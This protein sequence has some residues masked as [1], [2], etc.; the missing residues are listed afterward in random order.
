MRKLIN[1]FFVAAALMLTANIAN[2]QQK[3][4]HLN[5]DD[6][7]DAMPEAKTAQATLETLA[8]TRQTE[9]EKMVSE[10]Q[11]KL[12]AAQDKEKVA[13]EK[14]RNISEANRDVITK[15]LDVLAKELQAA[16]QDLQD[17]QKRIEDAKAKADKDLRDK[18]S[19]LFP[20]VS[21]KLSTAIAAVAKEKGIAYVFDL[22]AQQGF[23]NILYADGG[24][25]LTAAVKTKL[26]ISTTAS[27]PAKKN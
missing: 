3:F 9:I 5:S 24:E 6:L 16:G 22:S 7:Y 1:V 12:K 2:A 15:E 21:K 26:G 13:Q 19:E 20:A 10:Y 23:N 8:K 27:T 17:F 14:Q 18:Q 4:G 25:D 11:T